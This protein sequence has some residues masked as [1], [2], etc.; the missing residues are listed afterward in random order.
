[1]CELKQNKINSALWLFRLLVA[2]FCPR[3]LLFRQKILPSASLP[4]SD[5]RLKLLFTFIGATRANDRRSLLVFQLLAFFTFFLD[6]K[7]KRKKDDKINNYSILISLAC[8][9]RD[10]LVW[11][12]K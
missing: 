4:F 10:V 8:C 6:I 9:V 11:A 3:I 2:E 7:K 12:Q 1:M 5:S